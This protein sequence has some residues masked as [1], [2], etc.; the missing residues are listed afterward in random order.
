MVDDICY[1]VEGCKHVAIG[2][3]AIVVHL[4]FSHT[5]DAS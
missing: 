3:I 1:M 5:T 4:G 2:H